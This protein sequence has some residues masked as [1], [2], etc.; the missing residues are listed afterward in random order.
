[1]GIPECVKSCRDNDEINQPSSHTAGPEENFATES[2]DR[3]RGNNYNIQN[4]KGN[5][6]QAAAQ[7]S[8]VMVK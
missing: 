6:T 4:D 3:R 8:G 7:L 5:T 2:R 1:L